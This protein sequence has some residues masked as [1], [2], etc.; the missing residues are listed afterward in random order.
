MIN[1]LFVDMQ[2]FKSN[3]NAKKIILQYALADVSF[4]SLILKSLNSNKWRICYQIVT[5]VAAKHVNIHCIHCLF[6]KKI[7]IIL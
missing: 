2:I 3:N 1:L 6:S 4:L 5:F 7:N